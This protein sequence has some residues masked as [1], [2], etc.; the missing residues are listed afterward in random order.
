MNEISRGEVKFH[1]II[2]T[3]EEVIAAMV[4]ARE[5]GRLV[6]IGSPTLLLDNRIHVSAEL[7]QRKSVSHIYDVP[8]KTSIPVTRQDPLIMIGNCILVGLIATALI[9][10]TISALT[11]L[12]S[13]TWIIAVI[14]IL[15][16]LA[17]LTAGGAVKHCPGC[18]G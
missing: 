14:V 13:N 12:F 3:R 9:T 7:A 2:G 18:R 17:L 10:L 5:E 11:W 1:D 15:L 6:S 16:I 8:P 4:R